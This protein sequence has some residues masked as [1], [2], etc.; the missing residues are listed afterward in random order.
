MLKEKGYILE[1]GL[2]DYKEAL[3]LQRHLWSKRVKGELPDILI[4]LEHPHVITVGRRGDLS[5][6]LVPTETLK[7]MGISLYHV[8]RGGDITYHGPGQL[9]V[10]P[11]LNLRGYGYRVVKYIEELE[12]V[13]IRVLGDFGIRGQRDSMNR[14][15]WV[16]GEKIA[17]I[18]VA[19]RQ[20]VSFHGFALNYGTDLKYFDLIHPC[21]LKGK[22]MV[23]MEKLLGGSVSKDY[24]I[25][26]IIYH[27]KEIFM[28]D[29][30]RKSLEDIDVQTTLVKEAIA[31]L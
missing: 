6:L 18:G 15:V 27:F 20:W 10:Y 14:G 13:L 21:G 1:F 19:I 26:R 30:I 23:S 3:A 25:E 11:I 7:S 9:I 2:I 4:V 5:N 16:D 24:L 12:E 17:S 8:E 31:I 28:K 22:K 29:W